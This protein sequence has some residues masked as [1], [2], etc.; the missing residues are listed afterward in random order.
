MAK[1]LQFNEEALKAILEG[2]EKLAKA[3]KATLG[4]KGR[5]VVIAKEF[6][7]PISTKDG[8]SVAKEISLKNKFENMGVELMKQASSKTADSAGDG[9]TTAIVLAEAIVREGVKNVIAGADPMAIKR[10]ISLAADRVLQ[11]LDKLATPVS[12]PEEIQQVATLA[13]NRDEE[14]GRLIAKAL[15][16]VGND[17]AITLADAKGIETVLDVVEG[18]QF[19]KGYLSPYFITHPDKM[20]AELPNAQILLTDE[21][22]SS[23]KDLVPFL[24]KVKA[25]GQNPLFI[26]A[27][28]IDGEA[29]TTLV[30]NK[31]KGGFSLCAAKA[32]AFGDRCKAILQD[33]A[34]LTGATVV[35]KEVGLDLA[36]VGLEV[37]GHAAMARSGK[38][39]TTLIGGKGDVAQIEKRRAHIRREIEEASS[40]YDRNNLEDRL[41]KLSG[42]V[43]VIRIGAATEIEAKE[44]KDRFEDAICATKA[45][46]IGGI[47]P[48]GGVG[49]LRAV[50]GLKE[51]F[52]ELS[53]DEKVGVDIVFRAAFAPAAAIAENCGKEGGVVAQRI[54]ES[55]GAWGFNGLKDTFEDLLEAHIIDPA[56]VTRSALSYAASI[57]GLLL[58]VSCMITDKPQPKKEMA[59][60]GGGMGGMGGMGGGFPGGMGGMM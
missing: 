32:P 21:K 57:A 11:R 41:A 22:I 42:G 12:K 19:D 38:E 49:L 46:A 45:A 16:K 24:E 48:G 9:T 54:F 23:A 18:Q 36:S 15:Q 31:L 59:A 27:E 56:L 3:V 4:P 44:K 6:G 13:A 58:T 34:V 53:D 14:A 37:L 28:D 33:I 39:E 10:G 7:A 8:V 2:G 5:N 1:M 29:L 47:I 20:V 55:K 43:A 26:I 25:A 30:L 50:E 52:Q 35:S 40:D 60:D 17:G 51:E